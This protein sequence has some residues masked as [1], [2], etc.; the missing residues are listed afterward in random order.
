MEVTA[1]ISAAASAQ[2]KK[3]ATHSH[4]R[5]LGLNE[6]GAAEPISAG[7]VGQLKAREVATWKSPAHDGNF[8]I[9][10]MLCLLL[11]LGCWFNC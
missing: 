2:T 11:F 8:I 6:G 4:I 5:G 7:F 10:L 3:V 1:T 9:F